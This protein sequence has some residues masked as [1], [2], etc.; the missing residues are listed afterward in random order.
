M[1]RRITCPPFTPGLR[2]NFRFE[3]IIVINLLTFRNLVD[4]FRKV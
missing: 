3:F 4:E 2:T 1:I